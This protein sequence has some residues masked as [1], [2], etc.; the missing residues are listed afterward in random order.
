MQRT[1]PLY[2]IPTDKRQTNDNCRTLRKISK[3]TYGLS[4]GSSGDLEINR[5]AENETKAWQRVLEKEKES[6]QGNP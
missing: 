1:M 3:D 6:M 4:V 5:E 2:E